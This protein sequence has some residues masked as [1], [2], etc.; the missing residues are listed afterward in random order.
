MNTVGYRRTMRGVIQGHSFM[1]TITSQVDDV[2]RYSATVDGVS[3]EMRIEG[4]IR[5]KG[6]AMQLG[7]TAV[8]RHIARLR[9][10]A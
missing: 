4:V 5:N 8:E 9:P 7:M 6:D 3:V 10:P 1:L 2:F